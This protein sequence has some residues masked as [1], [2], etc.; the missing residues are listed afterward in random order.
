MRSAL[1]GF[2]GHRIAAEIIYNRQECDKS[3]LCVEDGKIKIKRHVAVQ[4]LHITEFKAV[5]I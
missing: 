3:Y 4:S 2:G 1:G 5:R